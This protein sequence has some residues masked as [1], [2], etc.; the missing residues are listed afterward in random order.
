MGWRIDTSWK[1]DVLVKEFGYE[2]GSGGNASFELTMSEEIFN[3]AIRGIHLIN[4]TKEAGASVIQMLLIESIFRR[5]I[6]RFGGENQEATF[7]SWEIQGVSFAEIMSAPNISRPGDHDSDSITVHPLIMAL[8]CRFIYSDVV[9]QSRAEEYIMRALSSNNDLSEGERVLLA[10]AVLTRDEALYSISL[11]YSGMFIQ[12]IGENTIAQAVNVVLASPWA[13]DYIA[14]HPDLFTEHSDSILEG[15]ASAMSTDSDDASF[16]MVAT[17]LQ[18]YLE[19]AQ[20]TEVAEALEQ[21]DVPGTSSQATDT[22]YEEN[23]AVESE[24]YEQVKFWKEIGMDDEYINT[25]C[26]Q[27]DNSRKAQVISQFMQAV[28]DLE[29]TANVPTTSAIVAT[30][31]SDDITTAVVSENNEMPQ[32]VESSS[33]I[34]RRVI[35]WFTSLRARGGDNSAEA[36]LAEELLVQTRADNMTVSEENAREVQLESSYMQTE[37]VITIPQASI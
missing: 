11:D 1:L 9:G 14:A 2:K 32:S 16:S 10:S 28:E 7:N 30:D 24:I 15:I 20:L 27:L 26:S 25:I 18:G 5:Y 23:D 3:K 22:C 4:A 34:I 29:V 21:D 13:R 17:A 6:E 31:I 36:G 12:E 35:D 37:L 19:N 33:G 8:L